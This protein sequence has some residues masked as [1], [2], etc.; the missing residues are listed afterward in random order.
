MGAGYISGA[1]MFIYDIFGNKWHRVRNS[2][3]PVS[4]FATVMLLVTI[5]HYD[6][7]IHTNLAFYLWSIIYIITPFLVPW[8]W[9]HNSKA[10]PGSLETG[11][12]VVP[13]AIRQ[14]IGLLGLI[15]IFFWIVNFI[16]PNLMI[17]F[18][19]W[20]LTPLSARTICAR[21][22]LSAIGCL[23]LYS[24]TRWSGWRYNIQAIAI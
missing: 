22:T 17:S 20:K 13:R 23:V 16:D 9:I 5:L 8:L 4:S 24:E 1:F 2:L 21:G 3:L 18:W 7:F 15:T 14:V 10:D 19:P 11:D 12:K 6:R